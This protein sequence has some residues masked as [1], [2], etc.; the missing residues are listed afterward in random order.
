LR[1]KERTRRQQ[2]TEGEKGRAFCRFLLLPL[3]LLLLFARSVV[4]PTFF[5]CE[6]NAPERDK[7][8]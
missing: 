1:Q 2:T 4:V 5:F 6:D 3:L 7:S 8:L